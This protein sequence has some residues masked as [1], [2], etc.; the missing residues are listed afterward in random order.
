MQKKKIKEKIVKPINIGNNNFIKMDMLTKLQL[1]VT[2]I[3][4]LSTLAIIL[5]F[6]TE[7][8][9]AAILIL[10]SYVLVFILMVKLLTTKEL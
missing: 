7:F 4:I 1:V 9:V 3:F 6:I 2:S 10:I 8:V 5:V